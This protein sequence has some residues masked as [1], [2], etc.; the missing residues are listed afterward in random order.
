MLLSIDWRRNKTLRCLW[1]HMN[2]K[3]TR[4]KW[5][6]ALQKQ[7]CPSKCEEGGDN[8]ARGGDPRESQDSSLQGHRLEWLLSEKYPLE[9]EVVT[10]GEDT[11]GQKCFQGLEGL[12]SAFWEKVLFLPPSFLPS[13]SLPLFFPCSFFSSFLSPLSLSFSSLPPF[14]TPLFAFF[15]KMVFLYTQVALTLAILLPQLVQSWDY[16]PVVHCP[17]KLLIFN[18]KINGCSLCQTW[19]WQ[20]Q[21]DKSPRTQC[22]KLFPFCGSE[23]RARV[24]W[25]LSVQPPWLLE[26]S[27]HS[28]FF[29]TLPHRTSQRE[30]M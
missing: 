4:G 6:S 29:L 8:S 3:T 14:L 25:K 11:D 21:L 7:V 2:G 16:R 5:Q 10:Q 28:K 19:Y 27:C 20:N 30:V 1:W 23:V 17:G 24:S 9:L 26:G 18:V 22:H 13:P 12:S 15:W